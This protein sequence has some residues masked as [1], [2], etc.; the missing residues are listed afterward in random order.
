MSTVVAERTKLTPTKQ[1]ARCHPRTATDRL[2]AL[3]GSE[4]TGQVL[5]FPQI[6]RMTVVD[7]TSRYCKQSCAFGSA[8]MG[9]RCH[10]SISIV[11]RHRKL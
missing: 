11:H 1:W 9:V 8:Y 6:H 10:I 3:E 5:G 7:P 2:H 4:M